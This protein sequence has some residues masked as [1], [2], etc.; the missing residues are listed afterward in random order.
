MKLSTAD[1]CI[2]IQ[3]YRS[4]TKYISEAEMYDSMVECLPSKHRTLP[5]SDPQHGRSGGGGSSK[6]NFF[7]T[8]IYLFIICTHICTMMKMW[9]LEGT[10]W[11]MVLSFYSVS[12]RN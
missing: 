4:L 2:P 11:E 3:S 7:V 1:K 6:I 9:K 8:F 5:E 12:P 10:L